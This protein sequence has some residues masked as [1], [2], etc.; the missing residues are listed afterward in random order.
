EED[1]ADA[2]APRPADTAVVAESAGAAPAP[3]ADGEAPEIS[4][5]AATGLP[6][7]PARPAAQTSDAQSSS[8]TLRLNTRLVDVNVVAL[9]KKGHPIT[10]LKPG[11]FE[12]Y[13][14]GVKQDV[15]SF[16]QTENDAAEAPSP[17]PSASPAPPE[18]SNRSTN[19]ANPTN[20]GTNTVI[21]LIDGSNLAFNDLVD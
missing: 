14:N 3:A 7:T 9:D 16:M 4:T 15:R 11:D 17:H 5:S 8:M 20:A 13:D 12:V 18:F 2:P 10:N 6:D 21:I 1:L 19:D